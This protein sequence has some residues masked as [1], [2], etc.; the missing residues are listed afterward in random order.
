MA[1]IV[2]HRALFVAVANS[3]QYGNGA[4]IAPAALLDDGM[5]EIVVVEPQSAF[6]ILKQ[7][8]AFFQ[9]TL[10]EGPGVLMRSAASMD[11]SCAHPI[12]FHVD[13]EPRVGP[14]SISLRTRRSL[15]SV[16]VSR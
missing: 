16:K 5:M 13:G 7:V 6:A 10:R 9:G 4:Q 12:R 1:D 11:I 3:R 8:P 15:L 14:Q 2:D